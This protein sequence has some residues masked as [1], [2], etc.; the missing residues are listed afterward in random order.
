M[1]AIGPAPNT[2]P[3]P[4]QDKKKRTPGA[5]ADSVGSRHGFRT[6]PICVAGFLVLILVIGFMGV[7][8]GTPEQQ[9]QVQA[10]MKVDAAKHDADALKHTADFKAESEKEALQAEQERQ[11]ET[12]LKLASAHN[13]LML[14]SAVSGA[15]MLKTA[16]RNPDT[17]KLFDV[18]V[19][20]DDAVCYQYRAQNG[21]GVINTEYAVLTPNERMYGNNSGMWNR[22]CK[23]RIGKDATRIVEKLMN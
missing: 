2:E 16:I 6:F 19:M 9:V 8:N 23:G 10:Q 13:D 11:A 15:G 20:P 22:Y 21:F 17:L 18:S 5:P 3:A 12:K 4:R 1:T 7:A 14:Q